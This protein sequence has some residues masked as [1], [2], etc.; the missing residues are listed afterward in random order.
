[1][2]RPHS[3]P[4]IGLTV[5]IALGIASN[6]CGGGAPR[7]LFPDGGSGGAAAG[8]AG[9]V[10][11]GSTSVAG[12]TASGGASTTVGGAANTSGALTGSGGAVTSGSGGTGAIGPPP[13]QSGSQAIDAFDADTHCEAVTFEEAYDAGE[14]VLTFVTA[15]HPGSTWTHAP[16]SRWVEDAGPT[17]FTVCLREDSDYGG[18]HE[19]LRVD[20]LALPA[21]NASVMGVRAG[22][23][24]ASGETC[25]AIAFDPPFQAVPELQLALG[26]ESS[27]GE[28]VP[29]TAW[30]E[31][32]SERGFE[33]CAAPLQGFEGRLGAF[34]FE[35][36]AIPASFASTRFAHGRTALPAFS[37][38]Y[39]T[40]VET[41]CAACDQLQL[42]VGQRG[43][44]VDPL[45]VWAED[46]REG[47]FTLCARET[48]G[49][50]LSRAAGL[51]VSW[52][53]EKN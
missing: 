45:L 39:C 43:G 46:F 23:T 17:G 8:S 5:W 31:S 10:S 22:K 37:D 9:A 3:S 26:F 4:G 53:L 41:P 34:T 24:A 33:A 15:V 52:L 49:N 28:G 12:R 19:A 20:W 47:R 13:W 2:H 21:S 14:S 38:V 27:S 32:V 44:G 11:G 1:M 42:G 50:D 6:A 40:S 36:A 7:D 35:W 48:S 29:A 30:A 18:G 16:L 51:E 25:A